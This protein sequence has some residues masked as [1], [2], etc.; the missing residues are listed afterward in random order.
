GII[1][2][3]TAISVM[4][5]EEPVGERFNLWGNDYTIIGVTK[6]FHF[7]SLHEEVKPFF[8]RITPDQV[9]KVMVRMEA[10]KETE[11]LAILADFYKKFNPGYSFDYHFLDAEYQALYA[12]EQRVA[13]L[14]K[15]FSVLAILISCLGLFGLAA[16]TAER[17]LKEI[18][19]R[20][21]LGSSVGGIVYLLSGDFNKIVLAAALIALPLSYFGIQYWL[22]NF[23]YRIA[24]EWWYFIGAV[25]IALIITWLTVGIHAVRAARVNPVKCLRD[26]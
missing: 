19:I 21:V 23:A 10:G 24:L 26:E 5:L 16:F 4:G 12:A 13:A 6:D 25:L 15:Y 14:S 20:K 3:E 11:T 9:R 22:N 2:N 7:T 18:G 8:F 17:R 1:L